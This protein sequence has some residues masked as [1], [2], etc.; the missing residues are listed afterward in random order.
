MRA[1]MKIHKKDAKRKAVLWWYADC[2]VTLQ[3]INQE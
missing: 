1:Q 2:F 3:A